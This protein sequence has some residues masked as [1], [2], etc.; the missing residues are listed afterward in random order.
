[1]P[2]HVTQC[3]L[4]YNPILAVTRNNQYSLQLA[5][6]FPSCLKRRKYA[7]VIRSTQPVPHS[8]VLQAC[9]SAH[10]SHPSLSHILEQIQSNSVV[11]FS[12]PQ[13]SCFR[14]EGKDRL[15]LVHNMSSNHFLNSSPGQVQWTCFLTRTGRILDVAL[16]LVLEEMVMVIGSAEKRK[17]LLVHLDKH[18]FPLDEVQ[19][20]DETDKYS[21][22]VLIGNGV[23]QFITTYS[24]PYDQSNVVKDRKHYSTRATI[25]S[26]DNC[27]CTYIIHQSTL[28]PVMDGYLLV[29][30]PRGDSLLQEYLANPKQHALC[31]WNDWY[32]ECLRVWIGKGKM[33]AEWTDQRTPLEA[34]LFPM[35]SFNKGCYI[36][37]E[38]IARLRTYGGV[39]RQLIGFY[40]SDWIPPMTHVL[41]S[42]GERIG[43][44]TSCIQVLHNN[45]KNESSPM[46]M[47]IAIGYIQKEWMREEYFST[48]PP[49]PKDTC[50]ETCFRL[51]NHSS[52]ACRLRRIPFPQY[53]VHDNQ[54][55]TLPKDGT[56]TK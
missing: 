29:C 52:V 6:R 27:L 56:V 18:I 37:Q 31:H 54:S 50:W 24:M 5:K 30:T 34:G 7:S 51:A 21:K 11:Y 13:W 53:Q 15:S 44:I 49:V 41:N 47:A 22:Y 25:L 8:F 9:Q 36:G 2:S 45:M 10:A 43:I 28:E 33:S 4:P 46:L 35:I 12:F 40:V 14:L 19:V 26:K 17:D 20:F 55:T 16:V 39:K 38:T 3:F 42:F 1:M 48:T 23:E 32:W